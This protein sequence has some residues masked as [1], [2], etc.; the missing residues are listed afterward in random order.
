MS[1]S[2]AASAAGVGG[3]LS[4]G[5]RKRRF[6]EVGETLEREELRGG[7]GAERFEGAVEGGRGGAELD[8]VD[9]GGLVGG[10]EGGGVYRGDDLVEVSGRMTG[11]AGRGA[12]REGVEP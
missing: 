12:V 3:G 2:R 7:A 8:R 4:D 5:G 9:R 10:R 11:T 6:E 1:A